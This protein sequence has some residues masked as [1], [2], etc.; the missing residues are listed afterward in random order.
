MNFGTWDQRELHLTAA[1]IAMC[2]C[3]LYYLPFVIAPVA[4]YMARHPGL[5][6]GIPPGAGPGA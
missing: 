6:P 5:G 3:A 4:L 2:V 1:A